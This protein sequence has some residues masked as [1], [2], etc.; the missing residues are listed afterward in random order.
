MRKLVS[1][2]EEE[3]RVLKVAR[4]PLP[5]FDDA[6]RAGDVFKEEAE[7]AVLGMKSPEEAMKSVVARVKPMLPA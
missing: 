4:V 2:A 5:A 7:A 3:R 6:A 1:Y